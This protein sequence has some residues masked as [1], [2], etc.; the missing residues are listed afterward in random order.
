MIQVCGFYC[1][2]G[3][4]PALPYSCYLTERNRTHAGAK[5]T[6]KRGSRPFY[7]RQRRLHGF[8]WNHLNCMKHQFG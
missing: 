3:H 7:Q 6:G 4:A 2:T 1:A 5:G 8:F